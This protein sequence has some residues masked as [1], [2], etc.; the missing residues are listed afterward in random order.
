MDDLESIIALGAGV[1]ATVAAPCLIRMYTLAAQQNE[2]HIMSFL[3]QEMDV[4][5]IVRFGKP[6]EGTYNEGISLVEV[7]CKNNTYYTLELERIY[8]KS[9]TGWVMKHLLR[10]RLYKPIKLHPQQY[11]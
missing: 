1:F 11:R 4:D 10:I 9:F 7:E 6:W 2:E 8:E 3:K 5:T